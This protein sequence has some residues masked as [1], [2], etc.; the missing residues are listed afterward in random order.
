MQRAAQGPW[1]TWSWKAYYDKS[2][3]CAAS[4]I[5]S[6]VGFQQHDCVNIIGFNSP[7]WFVAQM[8]AILAGGKAAGVYTTNE[9]A[10]CK[11]QAVHSDAKVIFV[12]DQK[13]LIKY[14][15]FKDEW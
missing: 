3:A 12:E 7:E 10:A 1:E 5:S 15:D 8:G 14:L 4:L 11:Y 6:S 13:Q 9:P 2:M